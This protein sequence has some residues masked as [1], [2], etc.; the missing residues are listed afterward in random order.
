MGRGSERVLKVLQEIVGKDYVSNDEAILL[1]YSYDLTWVTPKMP[2]YVVMPGSV[3][4]IQR[5]LRFA[6]RE[7]IPVIPYVSA[8]T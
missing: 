2:D 3:E 5:I 7:K 4:E 1:P 8:R 6:N